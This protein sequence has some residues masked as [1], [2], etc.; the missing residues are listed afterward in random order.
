MFA[1]AFALKFNSD[2]KNTILIIFPMWMG[3]RYWLFVLTVW[4]CILASTSYP[5]ILNEGWTMIS[6]LHHPIKIL[7]E[8]YLRLPEANFSMLIFVFFADSMIED[9]GK[10]YTLFHKCLVKLSLNIAFLNPIWAVLRNI[11]V[12]IFFFVVDSNA[13]RTLR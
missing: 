12:S 8:V 6:R 9:K 4:T 10:L 7:H 13:F 11:I 5:N 1:F 2:Q 3:L